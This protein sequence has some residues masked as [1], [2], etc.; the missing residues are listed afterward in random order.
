MLHY[1]YNGMRN[2]FSDASGSSISGDKTGSNSCIKRGCLGGIICVVFFSIGVIAAVRIAAG[3]GPREIKGL[4]SHFPT[5]LE[6]FEKDAVDTITFVPG[7]ALARAARVERLMHRMLLGSIATYIAP[8]TLDPHGPDT[9][10]LAWKHLDADRTTVAQ[11]YAR[12]IEAAHFTLSHQTDTAPTS[13][14]SFD[15][16][17]VHGEVRIDDHEAKKNTG[18]AVTVTIRYATP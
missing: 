17:G 9:V 18:A 3:P 16:P 10:V 15:G 11:H 4:P 6:L 7:E 13:V 14:L 2:D 8:P 1:P 5:A 12:A